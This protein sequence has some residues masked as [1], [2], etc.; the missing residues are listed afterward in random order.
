MKRKLNTLELRRL[1][2]EGGRGAAECDVEDD[3][4]VTPSKRG[5][6]SVAPSSSPKRSGGKTTK[7]SVAGFGKRARKEDPRENQD[8][9]KEEIALMFMEVSEKIDRCFDFDLQKWLNRY[10]SLGGGINFPEA[11][12]L[13]MSAAQIYGRKVDYLE[14][15]ILH[16]DQDQKGREECLREEGGDAMEGPSKSTTG[17][18]RRFQPQSLSDCFTDLEFSCVDGKMLSIESLVTKVDRVTV[19][20]RNKF[21]QMQELCNE[22]RSMPTKQ[23]RQEILNRLRDEANIPPIMSSHTA[24]RKNQVLDLESG[25]TIGTRYDYQVYLN[26][27]DVRTGS[28]I[29]E[30][31]LKKFFQRCDVIDYLYEQQEFDSKRCKRMGQPEPEKVFPLKP[32]E[33]KIYIPPDYLQNKYRIRVHD[34]SDF[35]NALHQAK[36]SNYRQD[37]ILTLM[38]SRFADQA[39]L[40]EFDEPLAVEN[41]NDDVEPENISFDNVLTSSIVENVAVPVE[42]VPDPS[43]ANESK[44]SPRQDGTTA[45][46]TDSTASV[47]IE[48]SPNDSTKQIDSNDSSHNDI[49]TSACDS[50]FDEPEYP[51]M[52]I[53]DLPDSNQTTDLNTST[54]LTDPHSDLNTSLSHANQPKSKESSPEP[55]LMALECRSLNGTDSLNDPRQPKSSSRLSLEDEGI[56]ADRESLGKGSPL[57]FSSESDRHPPRT[58]SMM[59]DCIGSLPKTPEPTPFFGG[60]TIILNGSYSTGRT[61]SLKP[62]LL[63]LNILGIPECHL[64]KHLLFALPPEYKRMKMDLVRKTS[65]RGKDMFTL[66]VYSLSPRA[67]KNPEWLKRAATP[68]LED[69]H[70]FDE[71]ADILAG[72]YGKCLYSL[73]PMSDGQRSSRASTPES[74]FFGFDSTISITRRIL[75]DP[76][77]FEDFVDALEQL[78][79]EE[80]REK[81][82]E[83][84]RTIGNVSQDQVVSTDKPLEAVLAEKSAEEV[85]LEANAVQQSNSQQSTPTRTMSR[86]SGISDEQN[87]RRES[88]SKEGSPEPG[89]VVSNPAQEPAVAP[90][91]E[92]E[93]A[94]T[95]AKYIQSVAE[96]KELIE[97]VNNWHRKLKPILI[98]SE[99][100]NHFDIHAYGTEIIDSFPAD[101]EPEKAAPIN[102]AHVM[103][104]KQQDCTARY[105]LSMLMLANTNN[106]QIVTNNQDAHRLTTK[107]DIELRLLSRKR[108][109]QE[110]ESMGERIPCDNTPSGKAANKIKSPRGKKRKRLLE[111]GEDDGVM[112]EECNGDELSGIQRLRSANEDDDSEDE[113]FLER[114]R[115]IYP[116][117]NGEETRRKRIAFQRGMR[118]CT[119]GIATT[120]EPLP[121]S[122]KEQTAENAACPV[123]NDGEQILNNSTQPASAQIPNDSPSLGNLSEKQV[124]DTSVERPNPTDT[125]IEMEDEI[126][127]VDL[128]TNE[129]VIGPPIGV[130]V[131]EQEPCCS[132]SIISVSE[133]GYQ[134]MMGL[135]E[136]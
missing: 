135:G 78:P 5:R 71:F 26:F 87:E 98:Q 62:T 84:E 69:C 55:E 114:I 39:K 64:R 110:M 44:D 88:R 101:V 53:S 60:G 133:S 79:A 75:E 21:Q 122:S 125:Q 33:F 42:N 19:D 10:E 66:A 9:S 126:L 27:I 29:P 48:E 123:S 73:A 11:A 129:A 134:S 38:K 32:R 96:A 128:L 74:E 51:L 22:L 111:D 40:P 25:E 49:N 109:H 65:D 45:D 15:M 119:Y 1:K 68:E 30:H 118:H 86:D 6:K 37:P 95:S 102:F 82:F 91:V 43:L 17:R 136:C 103:E 130:P 54:S 59:S 116:D 28:L 108:H 124:E 70:G 131:D 121:V 34:T 83:P 50:V 63:T 61:L 14:D 46:S 72:P 16:M 52:E 36:S 3:G 41:C 89:I 105:F 100:R 23:R 77:D 90:T 18:K 57:G 35:D 24:A 120:D 113:D 31:D 106:V 107:K 13:I 58:D 94:L 99:K 92:L 80:P 127:S 4:P 7:S 67:P 85:P 47:T 97:K 12:M 20:G 132:K 56:G 76:S 2:E 8:L 81:P 93:S 112:F 104:N 115:Q 117:M